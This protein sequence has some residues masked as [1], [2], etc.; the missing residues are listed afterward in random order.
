MDLKNG[1]TGFY[2]S[3]PFDL[4]RTTT[5]EVGHYLNLRHIWGDGNCSFDDFVSDTPSSDGPNYGCSISHVSCSSVDMVQNYM[6]Y[7][8][9]GCMNLFTQGQRDR[10]RSVL[11]AGGVRQSLGASQKCDGGVAPTCSDGVQ[12]GSETGI[13]CGGPDCEPCPSD[14]GNNGLSLRITFDNYP[15][16]TA[17][18]ITD[19]NGQSVASGSYSSSNP[20][21][22]TVVENLC[23]ENGCYSFVITDSYGDGIC[24]A[25][26]NGSYTLTD[27]SGVIASG[28]S[29][30]PN[31]ETLFCL[32]NSN[33]PSCDDG[34]QNGDEEGIDCGGISCEPC[35]TVIIH[36]GYFETGWDNWEDGGS[37]CARYS[38]SFAPEGNYA[39]RIRD[40]SGIA[41]SMTLNNLNLAS[42]TSVS[43]RF[44]F[45][46]NS[47]ENGEDFWLQFN[48]GSGFTTVATYARGT[49]FPGNGFYTSTVTLTGTEYNLSTNNAF[50]FRCDASGNNDQIYI[51][52]V[53][54]SGQKGN[55]SQDT[56]APVITL[57]GVSPVIVQVGGTY[58]DAGA[59]AS[60]DID[61]DITSDIVV[62]GFVNTSVAGTY[63]LNYNVAD[64]A[65][66]EAVTVSRVVIVEN[67]STG[68][69]VLHEGYFETG[70]DNW[71]DGGADCSR[72][73]GTRSPEGNASIKLRDNSGVASS[74]T[75]E[76]FDLSPYSTVD[77][78]F[79]FY[80]F[81][82]ENNEDF[83]LRYFDGVSWIT[84]A[85]YTK[86][87]NINNSTFYT[88]TVTLDS[89]T[90]NLVSNA[91]FRFQCDAS[92]NG[93]HIYIDAVVISA[94]SNAEN[95]RS[96]TLIESGTFIGDNEII[97]EG[98]LII[99]PQPAQTM[100][101]L[102]MGIDVEDKPDDITVTIYDLSGKVIKI[103]DWPKQTHPKFEQTI[104]VSDLSSGLYLL[105]IE[106]SNGTKEFRKILVK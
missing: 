2:L 92:G 63:S 6:D 100:I 27:D 22:S 60:D 82:M 79:E 64:A 4:G 97:F 70:W 90:Y 24:C 78:K 11:L 28:G 67:A 17:W 35:S 104:D 32:G 98:D 66:N 89:N 37:D 49:D 85:T 74:M 16:E 99:Y 29:F 13:D 73:S 34:I 48:D 87:L 80:V 62:T 43:I 54:I 25:Y 21:G 93:D 8:D 51:D 105:S 3:A 94:D 18:V 33:G 77:I 9:D 53:V 91:Q 19:N 44:S 86:G 58:T 45:Y 71:T 68:P 26:G 12:N 69:V 81:S 47:M 36:E 56:V 23:L 20:D 31:E 75:S 41:S 38:G 59:T 61:G 1:G 95:T 7:S 72:Y 30:G 15:E 101:T 57:N 76:V 39:I 102:H 14:C 42:Y 40:N 106:S 55:G 84:V 5:H 52:E 65:G 50:R 83:W 10:M 96:Q 103:R 46:A 88:S